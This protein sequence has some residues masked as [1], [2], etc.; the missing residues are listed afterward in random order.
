[1]M[2]TEEKNGIVRK[3][4]YETDDDARLYVKKYELQN[5]HVN[6]SLEGYVEGLLLVLLETSVK[7]GPHTEVKVLCE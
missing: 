1:M 2:K 7:S 5:R 4:I 6:L 3:Y